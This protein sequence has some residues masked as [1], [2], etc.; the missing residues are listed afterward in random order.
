[1]A[2]RERATRTHGRMEP[3]M[4]L[5]GPSDV[6]QDAIDA[7]TER[8]FRAVDRAVLE[9]HSRPSGL[10]LLLAALPEHHHLFRKVSRNPQLSAESIDANPD[11]LSIDA[12]RERAW[13]LFQP[14]YLAR[15]AGLVEAFGA[16]SSKDQGTDDLA[17]AARAAA[18]GRIAT[19]L[20]DAD[21]R[22]PGRIE[23]GTGAVTLDRLDHPDVDDLL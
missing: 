8:F 11:A 19:L 6:K 16:A 3:T 4:S 15:L 1:D 12:L 7:D 9:Y 13:R 10:P 18:G 21:R 2:E 22:I 17:A 20:V 5:H 14:H 23:P